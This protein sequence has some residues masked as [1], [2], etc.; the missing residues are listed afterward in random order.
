MANPHQGDKCANAVQH[1]AA[2]CAFPRRCCRA[3]KAKQIIGL[4]CDAAIAASP[5]TLPFFRGGRRERYDFGLAAASLPA[6]LHSDM[7]FLR[8]LP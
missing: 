1:C 2:G 5:I 6:F 3:E 7:N 8:S 4:P